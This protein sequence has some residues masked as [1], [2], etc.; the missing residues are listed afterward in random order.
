[1]SKQQLFEEKVLRASRDGRITC[2]LLR[3]IA[4]ENG[5]SYKQAGKTA[6]KLKIRIKSCDLGC[7]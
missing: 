4:Q 3:R 6:D 2:A 1:M 7:F 5:V